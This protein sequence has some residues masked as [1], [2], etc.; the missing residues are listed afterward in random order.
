MF[1]DALRPIASCT[2]PLRR[3]RSRATRF[4]RHLAS[5]FPHIVVFPALIYCSNFVLERARLVPKLFLGRHWCIYALYQLQHRNT[6]ETFRHRTFPLIEK[7]LFQANS[8][9]GDRR[10]VCGQRDLAM[11]DVRSFHGSSLLFEHSLACFCA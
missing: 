5:Y 8:K 6:L 9:V 1:T 11:D 7:L 10:I 3:R 4:K 2:H